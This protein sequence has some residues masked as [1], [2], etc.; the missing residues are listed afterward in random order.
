MTS[1]LIIPSGTVAERPADGQTGHTRWNTDAEY[2][3]IYNGSAWIRTSGE[4]E[5][6]VTV[7]TINDLLDLYVLVL[8]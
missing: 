4:S 5:V 8:G 2:M 1:G 7:D 3:E 6:Q